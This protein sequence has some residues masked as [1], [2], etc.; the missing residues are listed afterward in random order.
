MVRTGI[1][2]PGQRVVIRPESLEGIPGLVRWVL[3]TRAGIEFDQPL[4]QAVVD[5]LLQMKPTRMTSAPPSRN[6]FTDQ[7]G[8]PLQNRAATSIAKRNRRIV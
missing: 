4:H 1:L 8:R 3:E 5:H 7:F 2:Q 6:D